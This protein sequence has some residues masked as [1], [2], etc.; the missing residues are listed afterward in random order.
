[1]ILKALREEP[2]PVYGDGRQVRDWIHVEDHCRALA[3]VLE[4]GVLGETYIVGSEAP[5]ENI[6]VVTRLC[7]ILD[8]RRPRANGKPYLDLIQ[9]VEDRPGHD[10]RYAVDST[11]IRRELGWQSE[12]GFEQGLERT[13]NWYLENTD[14]IE[15]VQS[16]YNGARLGTAN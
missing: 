8:R 16:K 7:E 13:V 5:R 2:L 4:K 1:M 9:Y 3:T 15:T 11:K 14:W 6:D 12:L 10:L